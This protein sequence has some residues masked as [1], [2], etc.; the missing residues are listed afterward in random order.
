MGLWI[1]DD[2]NHSSLAARLTDP[3][4][5][6]GR[7]VVIVPPLGY[8]HSSTFRLWRLLAE[9]LARRGIR[10]LRIDP[11]ATGDSPGTSAEFTGA[12]DVSSAFEAAIQFLRE[13]GDASIA[14]VGCEFTATVLLEVGDRWNVDLMVAVAP[15][16]SGKKFAREQRM[17]AVP[18]PD[19]G[20]DIAMAGT[21]FTGEVLKSFATI[22]IANAATPRTPTVVIDRATTGAGYRL[23]ARWYADS[24]SGHEVV[25]CP[26]L[27]E[28]MDRPAEE[29][30]VAPD[31]LDAVSAPLLHRLTVSGLRPPERRTP[32]VTVIV[33]PAAESDVCE[34]FVTIGP[35]EL[36]GVLSRPTRSEPADLFV[37]LNSGS[38]PH[39]G[40]GRAWVDYAREIARSGFG[41]LRIDLRGWGD[42]PD[43]DSPPG[44]P[45]DSHASGDVTR[46]VQAL[47]EDGWRTISVGGLCAGAWVALDVAR[48]GA[49]DGVVAVN[50]QMYWQP[51]DPVEALMST[52]RER[53]GSEIASIKTSAA[54][55]VWDI[56]DAEGLRPPPARWLDDLVTGGSSVSLIFSEGDDGLEYLR[57]RLGRRLA[58]TLISGTVTV[59]EVPGIDHG[60]QRVWLRP[61]MV[62]AIR[63]ALGR[64]TTR[65]LEQRGDR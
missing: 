24:S 59:E 46:L 31:L 50:P 61:Q 41:V 56:Q 18:V 29:A 35:D 17:L 36:A 62:S 22:D 25:E 28:V 15:A 33:L 11:Y 8:R 43:N 32:V 45:Y 9:R 14:A 6:D 16:I 4:R 20:G 52:T 26:Q 19:T 42:S 23:G 49:V 3:S 7:A 37:L 54:Q 10:T 1:P 21:V 58:A 64:A 55:G 30:V 53:R 34:A 44:R 40:P 5:P 38:D 48:T 13:R 39:T 65:S 57:D 63:G 60:M 2:R 51:G 47:R 12:D 27:V